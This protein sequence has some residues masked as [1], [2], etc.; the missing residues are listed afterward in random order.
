V[1]PVFIVVCN[2][3]ST[4]ELVYKYVSGF[5]RD[6]GD[7]STTLENGRLA[8]SPSTRDF[9]AAL[10]RRPRGAVHDVVVAR[11]RR[12]LGDCTV[13]ACL[14][15]TA[16]E[17]LAEARETYRT[18]RLDRRGMIERGDGSALVATW[19][20]TVAT[21]S[22]ALALALRGAGFTVEIEDV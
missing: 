13:P 6:N 5:H 18:L 21:D 3:T 11:M 1:P 9:A 19:R 17:L 4:S 16:V 20:G 7:G 22:L 2:N 8:A 12:V 14:D 10:R 15:R